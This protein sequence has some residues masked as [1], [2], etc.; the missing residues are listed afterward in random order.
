MCPYGHHCSSRT[1]TKNPLSSYLTS[2]C[3]SW[4]DK[5]MLANFELQILQAR[6]KIALKNVIL[7]CFFLGSNFGWV[8]PVANF[9]F[10]KILMITTSVFFWETKTNSWRWLW[11]KTTEAKYVFQQPIWTVWKKNLRK[12]LGFYLAKGICLKP[13][14]T[15]VKLVKYVPLLTTFKVIYNANSLVWPWTMKL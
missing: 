3:S 15:L 8:C 4:N 10:V 1:T 13:K 9:S 2:L 14:L 12:F 5:Q 11:G 6:Q 7:C